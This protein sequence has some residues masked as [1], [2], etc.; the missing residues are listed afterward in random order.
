[1]KT[2]VEIRNPDPAGN[3]Y[4]Q[5]A[6]MLAAGLDGIEHKI[7]PPEPMERDIYHMSAQERTENGISSL[8]A[9]LGD[10]LE[11]MSHS[12][13]MKET[14]GDHIFEHYLKIKG[15]DW[16]SYRTHVTDWEIINSLRKL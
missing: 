2:R 8:P 1:M 12:P 4:L 15:D 9:N 14:L 10:A 6:V 7:T 3:P 11:I 16:D 13:L 5:F